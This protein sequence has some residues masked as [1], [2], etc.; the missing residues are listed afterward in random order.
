MNSLPSIVRMIKLRRMRWF[1]YVASM[2]ELKSAFRILVLKPGKDGRIIFN[3]L[4][5]EV[6]LNNI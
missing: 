1:G 6:N 4:K 5:P 3:P 2:A